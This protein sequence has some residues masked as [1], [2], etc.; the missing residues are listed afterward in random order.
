MSRSGQMIDIACKDGIERTRARV[1]GNLAV[2]SSIS[3]D[4]SCSI[5]HVPTGLRIAKAKDISEADYILIRLSALDW[6]F[7]DPTLCPHET[8]AEVSRILGATFMPTARILEWRRLH[9]R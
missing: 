4:D 2:H 5:T 1:V 7:K 9:A 6:G 3:R 8:K